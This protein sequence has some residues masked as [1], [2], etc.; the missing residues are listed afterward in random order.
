MAVLLSKATDEIARRSNDPRAAA[1]RWRGCS[2]S[3]AID[4]REVVTDQAGLPLF[5]LTKNFHFHRP[6]RVVGPEVLLL[7][8]SV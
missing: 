7:I 8:M 1:A 4:F 6:Q 2:W 3:G 5:A